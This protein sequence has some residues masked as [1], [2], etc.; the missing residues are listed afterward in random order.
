[1]I[2][3]ATLQLSCGRYEREEGCHLD[4][5]CVNGDVVKIETIVQST[6]P[7]T[8]LYAESFDPSATVSFFAGNTTLEFDGRGNIKEFVGFGINGDELFSCNSFKTDGQGLMSPAIALGADGKRKVLQIAADQVSNSNVRRVTYSDNSGIMWIQTATYNDDGTPKMITKEYPKMEISF[9]KEKISY[10]DTTTFN[11]LQ[12]DTLGNWTEAEV[13]YKGIL[14]KHD[15]RYRIKRQITYYGERKKQ[16]LI[17]ELE[18]YN[19]A[20]Y[21]TTNQFY[22]VKIGPFGSI[23]LPGYM[24]LQQQDFIN[25]V[26]ANASAGPLNYLFLSVYDNDDAYASFSANVDAADVEAFEFTAADAEYD[27][28]VN[29]LIREEFTK[30]LASSGV[31]LLKWLP[32]RVVT[33]SGR[34]VLQLSY[35]RCGNGSPIPVY[36]E[37]YMVP[38]Q[39]QYMV[40]LTL[41]YQSNQYNR[42][43]KDFLKSVKSIRL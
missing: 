30:T 8:E 26:K 6:I 33:L 28:G 34:Y 20:R 27:S 10:H 37:S 32:Y 17:D 9:A 1:M 29:S 3:V 41:S 16:P 38:V 15:Y 19:K 31:T 23:Q 13:V 43:R 14:R 2:A 40:T 42:F 25:E 7:V 22:N 24:R 36:C 11:Y 35:Y 5:L 12:R 39:G 21:A 4:K 18:A